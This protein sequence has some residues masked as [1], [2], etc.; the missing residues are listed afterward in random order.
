MNIYET[1]AWDAKEAE[2]KEL[3]GM[4]VAWGKEGAAK[5]AKI[6]ALQ[7]VVDKLPKT[8]DGVPIVPGMS[9]YMATTS[10][11]EKDGW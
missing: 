7:A 8:A 10:Q 11:S 1:R 4:L 3:A 5:D 6:A 2:L 9:T